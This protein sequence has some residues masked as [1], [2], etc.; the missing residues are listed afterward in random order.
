MATKSAAKKPAAKKT[1]AAKTTK[2]TT[3]KATRVPA[4]IVT[5]RRPEEHVATGKYKFFFAFFALTTLMFAAISVQLF[6]FSSQVLDNWE[7]LRK[8]V[9]NGTCIIESHLYTAPGCQHIFPVLKYSPTCKWCCL[10]LQAVQKRHR[11]PSDIQGRRG[12]LS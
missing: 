1:T 12:G 5:E 3:V 8:C 11:V 10:P 6:V 2:K 4:G 7:H 9:D